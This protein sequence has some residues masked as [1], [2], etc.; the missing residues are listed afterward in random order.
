MKTRHSPSRATRWTAAALLVAGAGIFIQIASGA[1]YPVVPPG[2]VILLVAAGVTAVGR[3]RWTPVVGVVAGVFLLFGLFASGRAS[4][5]LDPAAPGDAIGLWVQ[6]LALVGAIGAGFVAA[7]GNYR[8]RRS[9]R[10]SGA[11]V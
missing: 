2:L 10:A 1:E 8:R 4:D 9:T 5:L 3:W 6:V 7:R 11:G